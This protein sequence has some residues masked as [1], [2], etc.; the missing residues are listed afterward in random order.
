MWSGSHLDAE[1]R[2]R[3]RLAPDLEGPLALGVAVGLEGD[4]GLIAQE[5]AGGRGEAAGPGVGLRAAEEHE[6]VARQRRPGVLVGGGDDPDVVAALRVQILGE[7][8]RGAG[9]PGGRAVDDGH[10]PLEHL[11]GRA[12][13]PRGPLSPPP[14]PVPVHRPP[15]P[16][17]RPARPVL[18]LVVGQQPQRRDPGGRQGAGAE[19]GDGEAVDAEAGEAL[20]AVPP[21]ERPVHL[22]AADV[23][24]PHR[25]HPPG[26]PLHVH[27]YR[28][29]PRSVRPPQ[30]RDTAAVSRI[31]GGREGEGTPRS[32]RR[33]SGHVRA[34]AR[35]RGERAR[36]WRRESPARLPRVAGLVPRRVKRAGRGTGV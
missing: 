24:G 32:A 31:H 35:R 11:R 34:P 27:L 23:A 7:V 2:P 8:Q 13:G 1:P 30:L 3:E 14:F 9:H 33:R 4:E 28:Y 21:R 36:T 26:G 16:P 19:A 10:G 22:Q 5:G 6:V 25:P 17:P 29:R 18:V 15:F 12:V 20:R